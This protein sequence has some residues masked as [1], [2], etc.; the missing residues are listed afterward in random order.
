MPTKRDLV[1]AHAFSR[2]RLVTAFVSGA[3]GGREVEPVRPTR[4]VIGGIALGVLMVAGAAI[5]GLFTGRAPAG[6]TDEPGFILSDSSGAPYIV[7]GKGQDVQPL[8]NP[9]SARLILGPEAEPKRI[10]QEDID[11]R[12]LGQKIGIYG[13]PDSLPSTSLLRSSGW[14]MC[15]NSQAGTQLYIGKGVEAELVANQAVVVR[16]AAG[17]RYLIARSGDPESGYHRLALP[18]EKS[19]RGRILS[20]LALDTQTELQVPDSWLNLFPRATP[21]VE[22]AFGLPEKKRKAPYAASDLGN[23]NLR[24]GDLVVNEGSSDGRV[25]LVGA[26]QPIY[27]PPFAELVYGALTGTGDPVPVAGIPGGT[28][29]AGL[30]DWPEVA[31]EPLADDEACA[32]LDAEEDRASRTLLAVNPAED[33]SAATVSA[34][35]SEVD[36]APGIGAYVKTA[37]HG[38]ETGGTPWVVDMFGTRYRLGG[39][40]DETAGLLGY[41]DYPVP[42]IPDAWIERFTCGPELSQKAA[43]RAPDPSAENRC[44][45]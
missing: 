19:V 44:R 42:T 22:Q 11:K 7:L 27:L 15:S 10:A 39:P 32:V 43:L 16:N 14:T 28:E 8:Q 25:Y 33:A 41:G 26:E 4:T 35:T 5:A 36:V 30:A 40:A 9:I 13:A 31:P 45:E 23:G 34:S 2:R 12:E 20:A 37:S 38:D 24:V 17:Q 1:E 3:P 21:L 29:L 18:R 6:W